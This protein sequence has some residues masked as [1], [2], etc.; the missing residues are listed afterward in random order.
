M[1]TGGTVGVPRIKE[2]QHAITAVGDLEDGIVEQRRGGEHADDREVPPRRTGEDD[3]RREHHAHHHHRS[4]VLGQVDQ[5]G[6]QGETE[7]RHHHAVPRRTHA[8]RHPREVPGGGDDQRELGQLRWLQIDRSE[9]NPALGAVD[10]TPQHVHQAE[11]SE[12]ADHHQGDNPTLAQTFG[13]HAADDHRDDRTHRHGDGLLDEEGIGDAA[14]VAHRDDVGAHRGGGGD[15]HQ[16]E[17]AQHDHQEPQ[18]DAQPAGGH[19]ST[20]TAWRCARSN[21]STSCSRPSWP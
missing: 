16:A 21:S 7:Q 20:F 1:V 9:I 10:L 12:R 3:H 2:G 8:F 17:A 15:H 6:D 19:S 14:L 4:Q 11:R 18:L 13:T 5:A